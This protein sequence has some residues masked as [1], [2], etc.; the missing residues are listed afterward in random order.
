MCAH[1][2][3]CIHTPTP[4]PRRRSH[5]VTRECEKR[6]YSASRTAPLS[7]PLI[8]GTSFSPCKKAKLTVGSLRVCACVIYQPHATA[9]P[10]R[11]KT[12]LCAILRSGRSFP[13][14]CAQHRAGALRFTPREARVH[15]RKRTKR[16]HVKNNTPESFKKHLSCR[17]SPRLKEKKTASSVLTRGT[18]HQKTRAEQKHIL[19]QFVND[20]LTWL[21]GA[22]SRRR[23]CG[24]TRAFILVLP[25]VKEKDND[26]CGRK[27]A[28]SRSSLLETD[29]PGQKGG[30]KKT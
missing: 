20:C 14:L 17:V 3:A 24:P 15:A 23:L 4:A 1:E 12:T 29:N 2:H 28:R 30:K 7:S 27:P 8:Y 26:P 19:G 16:I 5:F 10:K 22:I 11:T 21:I 9:P 18:S 6:E 13:S 25:Q